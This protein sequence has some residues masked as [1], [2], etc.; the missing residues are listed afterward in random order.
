MSRIEY[1][2]QLKFPMGAIP[3]LWPENLEPTLIDYT[4]EPELGFAATPI[5][6]RGDLIVVATPGHSYGHQSVLL[7]TSEADLFFAGDMVFSQQQLLD[8]AIPGISHRV[9]ATRE[10]KERVIRYAKSRPTVF[11]PAHDPA[12]PQRLAACTP[13]P[14]A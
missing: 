5:T 11:L 4:N 8:N 12:A 7:R 10:S 6:S 2:K 13:L 1:E 14:L 9:G 3:G